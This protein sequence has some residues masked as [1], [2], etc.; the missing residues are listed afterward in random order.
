MV[1]GRQLVIEGIVTAKR[2]KG[3]VSVV[4]CDVVLEK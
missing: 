4:G 3:K 2:I 1:A